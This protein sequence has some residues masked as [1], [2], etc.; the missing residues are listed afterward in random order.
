MVSDQASQSSVNEGQLGQPP[1][2]QTLS[3]LPHHGQ[4]TLQSGLRPYVQEGQVSIVPHNPL[5]PSQ[6]TT[7]PRPPV[8][9]RMPL[10]QHSINHVG[11]LGTL[12]GQSNLMLPSVRPQSLGSLSVRPPIQPSTSMPPNQ[13]MHASLL[14]HSAL[15]G[16]STVGHNIQMVRPDAS[17]QVPNFVCDFVFVSWIGRKI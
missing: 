15:V 10:Q 4:S 8:Q 17:F 12:S 16:N 7:H 14:Q 2:L 9:P 6:L 3:G 5:V 11:Q 13:Q 1:V